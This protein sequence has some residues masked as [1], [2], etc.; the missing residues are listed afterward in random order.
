[1]STIT[2]TEHFWIGVRFLLDPTTFPSFEDEQI[3]ELH[4]AG[5]RA[6]ATVLQNDRDE[7]RAVCAASRLVHAK[8]AI[9]LSGDILKCF[10]NLDADQI[11]N[12]VIEG[13]ESILEEN[14]DLPSSPTR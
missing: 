10:T 11:I 7:V 3:T 14:D 6:T 4:R 9:N 13:A 2:A 12:C 1:M 8:A 5:K